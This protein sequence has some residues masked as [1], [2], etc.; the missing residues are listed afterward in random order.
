MSRK[1]GARMM[2][3]NYAP[4]KLTEDQ[5]REI[6]SLRKAGFKS[7]LIEK[8]YSIHRNTVKSIVE[9]TTWKHVA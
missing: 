1:Q 6:R 5:V 2:G 8:L 7:S 9:R 3:N 4:K